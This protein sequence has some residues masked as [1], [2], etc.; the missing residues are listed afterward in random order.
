MK[1]A[2]PSDDKIKI[3]MRTG[4]TKGFMVYE[5]QNKTII[6]K[7]YRINAQQEHD[8]SKE[9]SHKQIIELLKD[10]DILLVAKIG[11]HMKRDVDESSIEYKIVN[12]ELLEQIIDNYLI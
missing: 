2:I 3:T 1:I 7:E 5:I 12:D 8:E 9:H 6:N 10:V 4:Q 11:K